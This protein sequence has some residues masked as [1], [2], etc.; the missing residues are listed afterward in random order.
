MSTLIP[1]LGKLL[2]Y[3]AVFAVYYGLAMR[4][5]T[6]IRYNRWYILCAMVL[7]VLLPLVE[8]TVPAAYYVLA[9]APAAEG[10]PLELPAGVASHANTLYGVLYA[11]YA[12]VLLAVAAAGVKSLL[13]IGRLK[14]A[15]TYRYVEA[16]KLYRC[17]EEVAPFSFFRSVFIPEA[18]RIDSGEGR[19]ILLHELEHVRARHSFDKLLAHVLCVTFWFNPFFWFFRRELSMVHEFLADRACVKNG[20]AKELSRLILCSL[21]PLRH[22]YFGNQLL[23]SPIKRRLAMM[24][25]STTTHS[26]LRKLLILPVTAICLC[27]FAV[28]VESKPVP[29]VATE[30]LT[31]SPLATPDPQ[32]PQGKSGAAGKDAVACESV[33]VKPKFEG[34]DSGRSFAGWVGTQVTYPAEAVKNK[35]EGKT[36]LQFVVLEDGSVSNVTVHKSS[37]SQLLDNEAVRVVQQSPKWEPGMH[38]GAK[39][40]VAYTM[41]IVF[42]L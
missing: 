33:D 26:S 4:K 20:G 37:G 15:N 19:Q 7:S 23:Q 5:G 28:K 35:V 42:K 41:P 39:A 3:S 32:L 38:N 22:V 40:K 29:P 6:F 11:L 27:A 36:Y 10:V 16:V 25:N 1:Y 30:T 14:R 12:L 13:Y 8:L 9:G 24:K 34:D 17:R 18:I 21:Y 31:D 2:A